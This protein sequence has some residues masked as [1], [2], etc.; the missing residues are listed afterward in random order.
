[1]QQRSVWLNEKF[2]RQEDEDGENSS[3]LNQLVVKLIT[4]PFEKI[5]LRSTSA[6]RVISYLFRLHC[7]IRP[8]RTRKIVFL[9]TFVSHLKST[10]NCR[11][12]AHLRKVTNVSTKLSERASNFASLYFWSASCDEGLV[13]LLS[14]SDRIFK[15]FA[16]DVCSLLNSIGTD[17]C[18]STLFSV[19]IDVSM[20]NGMRVVTW[21]HRRLLLGIILTVCMCFSTEINL[22]L[23]PGDR[24]SFILLLLRRIEATFYW[25]PHTPF[26]SNIRLSFRVFLLLA[27]K[28]DE[29]CCKSTEVATHD[30]SL[31]ISL[32]VWNTYACRQSWFKGSEQIF[33]VLFWRIK[34]SNRSRRTSAKEDCTCWPASSM[35]KQN[36]EFSFHWFSGVEGRRNLFL[37]TLSLQRSL[38]SAC[39]RCV[40]R[41]LHLRKAMGPKK[42]RDEK[43]CRVCRSTALYSYFGALVCSPCKMF[44]KRN[45]VRSTVRISRQA[46]MI[47]SH[48][49][50][51][52][53]RRHCSVTLKVTVKSMWT[54][55]THV[56]RVD[57]RNVSPVECKLNWSE[58]ICLSRRQRTSLFK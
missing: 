55:G 39:Q 29:F 46:L 9:H 34:E 44:F 35:T 28:F 12:D 21:Q 26:V 32:H 18:L 24:F 1:M 30:S 36:I 58:G 51:C 22:T 42:S 27:I 13:F 5:F 10:K 25:P 3:R 6:V 7:R 47:R 40:S 17:A 37:C 4:N 43:I 54:I 52:S 2:I 11:R 31:R 45:A 20:T 57:W 48:L 53:F 16:L 15:Y 41:T 50:L 23:R 38:S 56:H 33:V 19:P 14:N 49:D 8:L